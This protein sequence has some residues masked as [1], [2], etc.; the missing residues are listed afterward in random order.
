MTLILPPQVPYRYFVLARFYKKEYLQ[1]LDPLEDDHFVFESKSR[2]YIHT[3]DSSK[4]QSTEM[5]QELE[6]ESKMS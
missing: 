1:I 2:K 6:N 3:A 5:E 4:S